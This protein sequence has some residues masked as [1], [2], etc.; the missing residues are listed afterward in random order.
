MRRGE[1]FRERVCAGLAGDVVEIGFGSGLNVPHYPPAVR[2]V[3]AVEPS[4]LAW[5]LAQTRITESQVKIRRSARDA[6]ALPYADGTFDHAVSTWTMC[7]IP[8]VEGALREVRRVL[9]PEGRLHF[10]EHGL[11]PD[12]NVVRWQRRLEPIQKTLFGGCHL[13]RPIV[14]L[15]QRAGF[16]IEALEVFYEDGAPKVTGAQSL[17]V[18]SA[19]ALRTSSTITGSPYDASDRP[20]D[21]RGVRP[22]G[23]GRLHGTP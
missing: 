5:K 20:E 1:P 3:D 18:A 6:Q 13:A 8:D 7:T 15:I 12:Q 19:P 16:T 11:A 21:P 17:G 10:V 2:E 14:A 22:A 4:S 9:R 23:G